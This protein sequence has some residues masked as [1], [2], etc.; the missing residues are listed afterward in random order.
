MI[1]ENQWLL[2]CVWLVLLSYINA[3]LLDLEIRSC[4]YMMPGRRRRDRLDWECICTN[5][6]VEVDPTTLSALKEVNFTNGQDDMSWS[7]GPPTLSK[8]ERR[9][10]L[11]RREEIISTLTQ[12]SS[13]SF[14]ATAQLQSNGHPF[15][16]PSHN[17][18]CPGSA[19][20]S[21]LCRVGQC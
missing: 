5:L 21:D 11:C 17:L 1:V 10:L 18:Y 8:W 4:L 3:D 12:F 15:L 19:S 14:M 16:H 20:V 9:L 7:G 6:Q 2:C 13:A